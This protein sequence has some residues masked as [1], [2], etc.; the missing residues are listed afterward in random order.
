MAQTIYVLRAHLIAYTHRE[1]SCAEFAS[2]HV[3]IARIF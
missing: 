1:N 3:L 2:C